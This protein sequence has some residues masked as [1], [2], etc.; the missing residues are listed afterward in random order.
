M[1]VR[2]GP[3][4]R[5]ALA[6]TAT[7]AASSPAVDLSVDSF[8]VVD[9]SASVVVIGDSFPSSMPPL[10]VGAEDSQAHDTPIM[11]LTQ[12][13]INKARM[14]LDKADAALAAARQKR[15]RQGGSAGGREAEGLIDLTK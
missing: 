6:P 13:A 8:I 11:R 3:G 14:K 7:G 2:A 5:A 9:D 4:R 10:D 1:S 15:K 12:A